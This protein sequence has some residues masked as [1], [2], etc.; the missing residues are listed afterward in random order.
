MSPKKG[1]ISIGNTSSNHEFSGDM[2]VFGSVPAVF[3]DRKFPNNLK[4]FWPISMGC[5][6][7]TFQKAVFV[8]CTDVFFGGVERGFVN[9]GKIGGFHDS[10]FDLGVFF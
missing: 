10:Q 1:R 3:W 9:P 6:C 7:E 8:A 5:F 2:L 4:R